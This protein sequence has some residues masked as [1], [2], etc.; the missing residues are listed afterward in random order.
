MSNERWAEPLHAV[1]VDGITTYA[2]ELGYVEFQDVVA[3][4]G[5]SQHDLLVALCVACYQ[6]ASG[7]PEFTADS[8]RR[9]KGPRFFALVKGALSAQGLSESDLAAADT[10][11]ADESGNATPPATSGAS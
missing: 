8:V 7:A 5:K 4:A 6:D 9:I 11:D 2:R 1:E 3:T 10:E